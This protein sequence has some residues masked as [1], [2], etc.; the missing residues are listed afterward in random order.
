MI[1]NPIEDVIARIHTLYQKYSIY[2]WRVFALI[3]SWAIVTIS[4]FIFFTN[5]L[6]TT[7]N[8]I[9]ALKTISLALSSSISFLAFPCG[10]YLFVMAQ[11]KPHDTSL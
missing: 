4:L 6:V 3:A 9:Y 1:S 2:G 11:I 8:D 7:I 10:T 5:N